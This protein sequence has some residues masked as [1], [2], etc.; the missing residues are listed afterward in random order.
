MPPPLV[1]ELLGLAT[2]VALDSKFRPFGD[3]AKGQA[4][5]FEQECDCGWPGS[6][7][8]PLSPVA[9]PAMDEVVPVPAGDAVGPQLGLE[10]ANSLPAQASSGQAFKTEIDDGSAG[11]RLNALINIVSEI[12]Q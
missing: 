1:S 4:R 5:R 8:R 11:E 10:T 12:I 7:L 3:Y 2:V 9:G 6:T